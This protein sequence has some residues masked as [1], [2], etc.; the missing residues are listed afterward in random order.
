MNILLFKLNLN[1]DHE[2]EAAALM[3]QKAYQSLET[4]EKSRRKPSRAVAN[5]VLLSSTARDFVGLRAIVDRSELQWR[6]DQKMVRRTWSP[7]VER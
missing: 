2:M 6:A 3:L 1:S 7:H 4:D 5:D